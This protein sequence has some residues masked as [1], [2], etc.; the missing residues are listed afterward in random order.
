M[1]GGTQAASDEVVGAT[2]ATSEHRLMEMGPALAPSPAP[3]ES[4]DG[5]ARR[6]IDFRHR[7]SHAG[8]DLGL[9]PVQ[10]EECEFLWVR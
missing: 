7:E 9:L 2:Q 10:G 3:N 5:S 4:G 6:R 1:H 8:G